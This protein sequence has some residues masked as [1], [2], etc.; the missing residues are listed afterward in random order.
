MPD[1]P[2][3]SGPRIRE[4]LEDFQVE[5]LPL[6][7]PSGEGG[8]TFLWIEKRDR[9][10]EEVARSLARLAGVKPRDVGYAGRKD[11]RAVARQWLSVPGL[12]PT[13]ALAYEEEGLRVLEAVPHGH[14]LRVGQLAG[15]R[16]AL[17]VRGVDAPASLRP[18]FDDITRRGF[19]NRFGRQRYGR[20]GDNAEQARALLGTGRRPRDRRHLR[21]LVS[22]LQAEIFDAALAARSAP[23]DAVEAGEVAQVRESGG[24]FVVED[25]ERENERARRFEISA[26]GPIFGTR[27]LA[28]SG[29]PGAR[30]AALLAEAGVE[31]WLA[32]ARGLR[33]RGGRR[34][35]RAALGEPVFAPEPDALRLGFVLTPGVYATVFLEALFGGP[36]DDAPRPSRYPPGSTGEARPGSRPGPSGG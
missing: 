19:A 21:F 34:A 15:N 13:R 18:R 1:P 31:E 23:L 3:L 25:L 32:Q 27:V 36:V 2:A 11:R 28:P 4:Q 26:T 8:H 20:R 29:A 10:T 6:Y 7:A 33:L 9:S 35:V 14:K 30:E 22:A 17:R 16:F 5:E 24:L 12:D